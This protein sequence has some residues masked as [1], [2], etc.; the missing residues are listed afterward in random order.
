[1]NDRTEKK[2]LLSQSPLDRI[3]GLVPVSESS[4][5]RL[6]GR[7]AIRRAKIFFDKYRKVQAEGRE[8]IANK[9]LL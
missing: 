9:V 7:E 5:E 3:D 6:T 8:G 4:V 1:M 2:S